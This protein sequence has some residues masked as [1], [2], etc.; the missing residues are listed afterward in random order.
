MKFFR[1]LFPMLKEQQ[2]FAIGYRL[3]RVAVFKV[4]RMTALKLLRADF[5]ELRVEPWSMLITSSCLLQDGVFLFSHL[6]YKLM[7]GNDK[8]G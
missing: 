5:S 3:P 4:Y 6:T 8:Y 1:E 2:N 7:K